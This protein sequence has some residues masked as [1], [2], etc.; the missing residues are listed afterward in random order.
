MSESS[1]GSG[2]EKKSSGDHSA[3]DGV[4]GSNENKELGFIGHLME[5]RD[6]LLRSVV[7]ILVIFLGAFSF[8][9]DIYHILALPLVNNL[10]E[11]GNMIATGVISP[12]LTPIKLAFIM[13]IFAA[14]PYLIFQAWGFIAPGLYK[15]E[16]KLAVP[17]I[18]SSAI[19]F[20]IGIVFAYFIVL[21]NVFAFMMTMAIDGVTHAPD[22]TYYL[23]FTLKMF[24]AFGIAFEVP[25]A[26]ILLVLG[27][28]TTPQSLAEKRPYIIVGAFVFGMLL[29]PPDP[30]SQ[31][32]LAIPM[33]VLF[34]LGLLIS[35]MIKK[36]DSEE[37]GYQAMSEDDMESE[38]D[39]I[40]SEEDS[41]PKL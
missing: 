23:D 30:A 17:L 11:G 7:V 16:K 32:M 26:T 4:L 9:N 37:D 10:P 40:E 41:G 3:K 21:P 25:V 6:R 27:G 13:S 14:F 15:H 18:I 29:T 8:A 22:I 35:R 24:F 19:L 2:S 31:I 34:E 5:L 28:V 12:F 36:T 38:L 33:W 20:Y 1:A 39:R